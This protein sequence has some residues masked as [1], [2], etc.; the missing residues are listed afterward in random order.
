MSDILS[1]DSDPAD[2]AIEEYLRLLDSGVEVDRSAF[3]ASHPDA[4]KELRSF[5]GSLSLLQKLAGSSGL[6]ENNGTDMSRMS[7]EA[8]DR[9]HSEDGREDSRLPWTS[10]PA[11]FGRYRVETLLGRGA[12]GAVYRAHDTQLDRP[13]A[14][15]LSHLPEN[16]ALEVRERML[17]EARA[18]AVLN[19]PRICRV[20]DVGEVDG[21]RFIAMELIEGRP[22][23]DYI[24]SGRLLPVKTAVVIIRKLA[25]AL[26]TA[27]DKGVVHRDLKPTNV[28]I[29]ADHEPILMDFGLAQR[30]VVSGDE[31]LTKDGMLIGSPAYMSPEQARADGA[32]I[33]PASD[34]YSL[35][36]VFF[37]L[38]T[39][40]VPFSGSVMTI[41]AKVLCDAPPSLQSIRPEID[42][43]LSDVCQKML[44]KCPEDRFV[45][46]EEVAERLQR[47]LKSAVKSS[48]ETVTKTDS[49][50]KPD[51]P[52][53]PAS[54]QS[55]PS[56]VT[57]PG[58]DRNIMMSDN[59]DDFDGY[60]KWLGITSKVRPPSHY[61]LLKISL[62][63]DD[64]DVIQSAAE[65]RRHYVES[66]RG[67]GH[68]DLVGEILMRIDEAEITLL[69][70]NLRREY[71]R[72]LD[73]FEKRRKSR[74]VDPNAT[75]TVFESRPGRSIGED[76]GILK[77][78]AGIVAVLCVAFA[79]MAVF[80]FKILPWSKQAE[81]TDATA[82]AA[83]VV[84]PAPAIAPVQ[85]SADAPKVLVEIP[86]NLVDMV[87]ANERLPEQVPVRQ[88]DDRADEPLI[89]KRH[90]GAVWSVAFSPDGKLAVS[91][92]GNILGE[93]ESGK[94]KEYLILLWD[95]ETGKEL[96]RFSGHTETVRTLA[97]SP[98]GLQ[99][100]SGSW[101]KTIRL[102]DVKSG[103]ETQ[104]IKGHMSPITG[105][106]TFTADG[107]RI[108]SG[109]V[110]KTA[111]MW[112]VRTGKELKSFAAKGEVHCISLSPDGLRLLTGEIQVNDK[113]SNT[114]MSL[115]DIESGNLLRRFSGLKGGMNTL[116]F[117]PDGR[118]ILSAGMDWVMQLWDVETG[119][120]LKQF[121]GH[122]C[123][124]T[125]DGKFAF[126]DS[127][128]Q[129]LIL[130]D[131]ETG[132]EVQRFNGHDKVVCVAISS[133][134]RRA[135]SGGF[136]KTVK[137][138]GLPER[139]WHPGDNATRPVDTANP[140]GKP[141]V[142]AAKKTVPSDAAYFEGHAYKFFAE[143]MTWHRAKQRCEE[144]GGHLAIITSAKEDQ[145]VA[146][147]A[148]KKIKSPARMDGFWLGGTDEVKEGDWNWIDGTG[149]VYTNW[150][151]GQPNNK[152]NQEHYLL[153]WL[154]GEKWSDQPDKS[155]QH[156]AFFICEWDTDSKSSNAR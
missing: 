1:D 97:F 145:F 119:D 114:V 59:H 105:G 3:I 26:K 75:T 85:A 14:L 38:I 76:N 104:F 17:Q 30:Q 133:D 9:S 94:P 96:K 81:Q 57:K 146:K 111:R 72:Q 58:S 28:I 135:L 52:A 93:G 141:A 120:E 151:D 48:Q 98:N 70:Y 86:P 77:T 69:N 147:L 87:D 61:E 152:G 22:L 107:N 121:E 21:T 136:D 95:V 65:Q 128:D 51:A 82:V 78:F 60:R 44:A 80:S 117:S 91:G 64:D 124:F 27:H 33:G 123:C 103:K 20:Y 116:T 2:A 50:A 62:D 43:D 127:K 90:T 134:G 36:V 46:M 8:A 11:M 138:W 148:K 139:H 131:L 83:P 47:W 34:I 29:N 6:V 42:R 125:P 45:S 7:R 88:F 49:S 53:K 100:V 89:F 19:D 142:I 39:G 137:V 156:K 102:W 110:D 99:I 32:M 54:I 74:K 55:K 144:M 37:E 108:L 66:K 150:G 5:F 16:T 63:E 154:H 24:H 13:V 143:V 12:M 115:W 84:V 25:L 129:C 71:D 15:K 106:I 112:D 41:L 79:A 35:G 92:Q 140:E 132:T 40:Q 118:R 10:L 149:L 155:E 126:A 122:A 130:W 56:S 18:A 67:S 68:D 4:A 31:R 73:L 23:A 113:K 109:S 153:Y 101:D